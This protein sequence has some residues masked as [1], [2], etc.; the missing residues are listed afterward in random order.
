MEDNNLERGYWTII[1]FSLG[2]VG[3]DKP[4]MLRN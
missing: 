4:Q 2:G 1:G 3:A